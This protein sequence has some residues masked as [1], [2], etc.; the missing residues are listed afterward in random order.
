[1][2]TRILIVSLLLSCP[3]LY[4]ADSPSVNPDPKGSPTEASIK[5]MLEV[6]QAHKMLDT[7][8]TQMTGFMKQTMSQATQG[9]PITPQ[10]QKDIDRRQAEMLSMFHEILNWEKLE[11][12]YTRVYQKSFTQGELSGM[13]DFYK[14]P[15]GQA[16]IAKMP[17]VMQN[18][19][20][21][22]QQMM[23]PVMMR[24]RQQQ[25][26]VVAEIKAEKEKSPKG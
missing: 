9:Q 14:T 15:A 25:Q 13:I 1:M 17:V 11:P 18:T 24:V 26:E 19:M 8:E 4:A 20:N 6:M 2:F 3:L 21:E 23:Q 12:M 10:I 16:M 5:Q 22:M 7:M